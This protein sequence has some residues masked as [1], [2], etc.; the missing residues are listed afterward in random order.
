M[1]LLSY[2]NKPIGSLSEGYMSQD[3]AAYLV[4]EGFHVIEIE[5]DGNCMFRSIAFFIDN[6]E[7]KH[8]R[9]RRLAVQHVNLHKEEF[10]NFLTLVFD[11]SLEQYL[12]KMKNS[13]TWGGHLE[14]QALS[15]V[16][17]RNIHVYNDNMSCTVIGNNDLQGSSP[18]YIA[19]ERAKLHYS[20]L[21]KKTGDD[22]IKGETKSEIQG[23]KKRNYSEFQSFHQDNR[24]EKRKVESNKAS[25]IVKRKER[26][27]KKLTKVKENPQPKEEVSNDFT[28]VFSGDEE[29]IIWWCVKMAS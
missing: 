12:E 27:Y 24:F 25:E 13:G 20:G 8:L 15:I 29:E 6:D 1:A 5:G 4:G 19:Y 14:L 7:E 2:G 3:F 28:K 11:G 23:A 16:L 9:Y 22:Q 10:G 18:I 17:G 26:K 21:K